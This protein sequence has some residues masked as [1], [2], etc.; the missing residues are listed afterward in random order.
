MMQMTGRNV[1]YAAGVV[2]LALLTGMGWAQAAAASSGAGAL[3]G[4]KTIAVAGG[5]T[6]YMGALAGQ[7]TPQ[8]GM[9]KVLQRVTALC[10]DR[11][12]LGKLAKNTTGEILAGFFTVTGKKLDGKPMEGLV[13]VYAPK[14]GGA[15]AAPGASASPAAGS[16]ARTAT[17]SSGPAQA[18]QKYSFPDGTGAIGLPM[19]WKVATAQKGQIN[20]SGPNG[21]ALRFGWAIGVIDPTNPQSHTLMPNSRGPAPQNFVAIPYSADPGTAYKAALTQFAQK[22]RQRTPMIDIAN[23]QNLPG[24]KNYMVYGDTDFNDG[25]GKQS[26]VLQMVD[27]AP[28][29]MGTWQM[30]L[31]VVYAPPQTMAA[32][33]NTLTA[34]YG[35]YSSNQ[36]RI[37]SISQGQTAQALAGE[38]QFMNT[39]SGEIDA[40][41]RSTAGFDNVLREQ[42]VIVDT[43]TGG[44]QLLQTTWRTR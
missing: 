42:T 5:G 29:M 20:A 14:T 40:A 34:I 7:P 32:E 37:A 8:A 9:G 12:V 1:S 27:T 41:D 3:T 33:A 28:Q 39:M 13:I 17:A 44:M 38:K 18:L 31:F 6:I 36:N 25:K 43:Q 16:G 19:G 2:L 22:A 26:F 23:V 24:G 10:G 30:T 11:P 4:I 21:E 15:T 35:S